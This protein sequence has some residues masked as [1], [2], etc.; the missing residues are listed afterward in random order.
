M[1]YYREDD[2]F[3]SEDIKLDPPRR[4]RGRA[5]VLSMIEHQQKWIARCEANGR[6]YTGPNGAAIR[7]ADLSNL[8]QWESRLKGVKR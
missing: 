5:L 8:R 4:A 7:Q 6:S 2:A 1:S 3:F